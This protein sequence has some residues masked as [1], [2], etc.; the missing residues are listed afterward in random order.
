MSFSLST[1]PA[2]SQRVG[3]LHDDVRFDVEQKVVV[4]P[5][6]LQQEGR[7]FL[8]RPLQVSGA[9]QR[10]A[11]QFDD[12]VAVF[13]ASSAETKWAKVRF[14]SVNRVKDEQGAGEPYLSAGESGTTPCT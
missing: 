10:P 1:R 8:Q 12:D 4:V 11:V 5:A 3:L 13:D 7:L 14:F 9:H 6:D 2:W